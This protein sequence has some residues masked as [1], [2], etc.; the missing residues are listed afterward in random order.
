MWNQINKSAKLIIN[1]K[2]VKKLIDTQ[3]NSYFD[4]S[5]LG[6]VGCKLLAALITVCTLGLAYPWA[7]CY[8][9]RWETKHTVINGHRLR[10]TGTGMQLFGNWIKWA[11]LTVFTLGIYGFWLNIRMK[12]WVV[13]HTEFDD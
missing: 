6:L 3:N 4:G 10:F 12:Q 11:L 1:K 13:K 8:L 2:D 5:L 7:L 9:Q